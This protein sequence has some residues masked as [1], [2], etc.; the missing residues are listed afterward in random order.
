VCAG[1]S[2]EHR[3]NVEV[4]RRAPATR[5]TIERRRECLECFPREV[6]KDTEHTKNVMD[7]MFVVRPEMSAPQ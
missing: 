6:T 1:S 2:P 7:E 3:G 4:G 5:F